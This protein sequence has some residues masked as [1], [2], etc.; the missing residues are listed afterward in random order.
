MLRQVGV[1]GHCN[2][3]L[4]NNA[5]P[6]QKQVQLLIFVPAIH[7]SKLHCVLTF[8]KS[9]DRCFEEFNDLSNVTLRYLGFAVVRIVFSPQRSLCQHVTSQL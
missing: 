4:A 8:F 2:T 7:R 3:T 5:Q 1:C 9:W 6:E